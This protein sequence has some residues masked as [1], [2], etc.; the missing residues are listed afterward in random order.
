MRRTTLSVTLAAV[1]L[2]GGCNLVEP[3]A[4]T[5]DLTI[6]VSPEA[7]ELTVG[8]SST[9]RAEAFGCGGRQ[10]LEEDMRWTS[11]DPDV[12]TVDRVSGHVTAIGPGST[13]ITGDDEGPYAIGPIEIPVTVAP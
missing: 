10:P 12:A 11:A 2:L 6:R 8:G 1:A 4:C 7:V 5:S 13:V 3:E 9:V